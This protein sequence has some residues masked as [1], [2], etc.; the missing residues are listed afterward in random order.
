MIALIKLGPGYKKFAL[1]RSWLAVPVPLASLQQR[2]NQQPKV[3]PCST[4]PATAG[5]TQAGFHVSVYIFMLK[6]EKRGRRGRRKKSIS[7]H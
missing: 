2:V 6:G 1:S 7:L 4:P 3:T 5:T